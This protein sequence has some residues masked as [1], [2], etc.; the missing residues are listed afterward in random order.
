M[1]LDHFHYQNQYPS[2]LIFLPVI[3]LYDTLFYFFIFISDIFS[4]LQI[5]QQSSNPIR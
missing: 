4:S 5:I 1:P 2:C 3:S